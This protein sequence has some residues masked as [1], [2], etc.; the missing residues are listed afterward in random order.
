VADYHKT[1]LIVSAMN[2]LPNDIADQQ[3]VFAQAL[4]HETA[5]MTVHP[6]PSGIR[7][8]EVCDA[9]SPS[10]GTTYLDFFDNNNNQYLQSGKDPT[11]GPSGYAYYIN[12]IL[13][14]RSI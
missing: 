9:C 12:S 11:V 6:E 3:Q 13:Y 2:M 8:P 5:E 4:S 10:Y 14:P 7:N 1:T